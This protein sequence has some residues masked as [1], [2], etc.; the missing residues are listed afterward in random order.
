MF[1]W[2]DP[3][4]AEAVL[5]FTVGLCQRIRNTRDHTE[6]DDLKVVLGVGLSK[7]TGD[8]LNEKVH[9]PEPLARRATTSKMH[10]AM[11]KRSQSWVHT[12]TRTNTMRSGGQDLRP[13]ARRFHSHS[14]SVQIVSAS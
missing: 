8:E 11:S 3:G 5:F 7:D 2:Y 1:L 9:E 6:V 12:L 4:E 10:R 14:A 13:K